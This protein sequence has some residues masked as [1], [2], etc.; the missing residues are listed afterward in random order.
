MRAATREQNQLL[1]RRAR[2]RFQKPKLINPL[3]APGQT[4]QHTASRMLLVASSDAKSARHPAAV[5]A[6]AVLE[7]QPDPGAP[8]LTGINEA[9]GAL[10]GAFSLD[11]TVAE[12]FAKDKSATAR[13][14]SLTTRVR[15]R[16]GC[17]S[18]SLGPELAGSRGGGRSPG[19]ASMP[20]SSSQLEMIRQDRKEEVIY[21]AAA[22]LLRISSQPRT[23]RAMRLGVPRF[24][25]ESREWVL[26]LQSAP[27]LLRLFPSSEPLNLGSAAAT[28]HHDAFTGARPSCGRL[29]F[30]PDDA[31]A[32]FAGI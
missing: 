17:D 16:S 19:T 13:D 10:L 24:L 15:S 18:R 3:P 23:A 8:A 21:M 32:S 20:A 9:L 7:A 2:S 4:P 31:G 14:V 26:F 28:K 22:S 5:T 1:L 25:I 30:S 6:L 29:R 12:Q 27:Y 11:V